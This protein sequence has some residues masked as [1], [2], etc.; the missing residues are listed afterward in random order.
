MNRSAH[1]DRAILVLSHVLVA[2]ADQPTFGWPSAP[3]AVRISAILARVE[4]Q[5]A[6]LVGMCALAGHLISVTRGHG[7]AELETL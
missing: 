1:R 4:P 2:Q 5:G 7:P 6:G 3:N